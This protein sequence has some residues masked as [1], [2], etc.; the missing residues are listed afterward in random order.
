MLGLTGGVGNVL[1]SFIGV[2]VQTT[3]TKFINYNGT[4]QGFR[5][6]T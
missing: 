3:I 1:G 4:L 2:L 6:N 5:M